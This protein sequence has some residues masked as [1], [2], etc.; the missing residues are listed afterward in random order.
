MSDG[1]GWYADESHDTGL[2]RDQQEPEYLYIQPD[3]SAFFTPDGYGRVYY[4]S[5]AEALK[6]IDPVATIQLEREAEDF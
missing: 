5:Q 4:A 6:E 1:Y 3:G 2:T